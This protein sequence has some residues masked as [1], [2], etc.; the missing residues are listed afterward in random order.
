MAVTDAASGQRN[1]LHQEV[2][3]PAA[4]D[5]FRY[6]ILFAAASASCLALFPCVGYAR[7]FVGL[8]ERVM[9]NASESTI[10]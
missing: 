1:N 3:G 7:A 6:A 10:L 9:G 8:W 2:A 4:P 5:C